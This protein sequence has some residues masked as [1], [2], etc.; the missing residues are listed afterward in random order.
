[1][2][3]G[4]PIIKMRN[5]ITEGSKNA[6]KRMCILV[7]QRKKTCISVQDLEY[8][9]SFLKTCRKIFRLSKRR[10]NRRYIF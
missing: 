6:S 9:E 1:M 5:W 7:N 2:M 10:G 8:T 3:H 4:Q